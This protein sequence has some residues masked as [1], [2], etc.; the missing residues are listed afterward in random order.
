MALT[1]LLFLVSLFKEKCYLRS[2]AQS[3][4][5]KLNQG[6]WHWDQEGSQMVVRLKHVNLNRTN[7]ILILF[8]V[9][10]CIFLKHDT[11]LGEG[12]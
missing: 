5:L 7:I 6:S 3:F 12:G 8:S 4:D 10:I 1:R 11:I 9:R 2:G